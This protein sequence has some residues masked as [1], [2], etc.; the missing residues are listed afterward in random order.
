MALEEARFEALGSSCHLL[1]VGLGR[2]RLSWAAAWVVEM[3]DRFSRFE[4]DSELSC[5][6]AR[7]GDWV[8]V[9]AE[10][11]GML[12]AALE[13]YRLSGG[14][15]HA[16]MLG[17]MLAIGY[18]RP[19]RFGPTQTAL[20]G[21][22]PPPPL[23]E[24]LQVEEGR[25]RLLAG[26]GIDLGGIAKGWLADRLADD[27]GENCLVNLGGDLFARGVGPA[28]DGWPVG[29]GGI[30]VLLSDQGAATSGTWRRAWALGADRLH[31]LI[32]PRTGRPAVSDLAEVSVV[33]ARAVDAEVHAKAALLLGSDRAPAYLAAHTHGWWLAPQP[34]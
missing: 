1:G 16:G 24:M 4:P 29:L 15:V 22:D 14:L 17:S 32:D 21:A 12:H 13:A 27:L 23:P 34:P 18:S 20:A 7:A 3:H 28:G 19:L 11:D 5:F 2:G 8:E 31:H 33:A 30:T 6:N 10:L 26:S 25:A 9:S